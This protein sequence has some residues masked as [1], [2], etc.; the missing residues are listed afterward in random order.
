MPIYEYECKACSKRFDEIQKF[1]DPALTQCPSCGKPALE[2]LM[3]HSAFH[4]KGSGYYATDYKKTESK[5]APQA[6][7]EKKPAE[8]NPPKTSAEANTATK[9]EPKKSDDK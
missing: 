3:S 4:L 9:T 8:T 6:D 1:S 2:R 7:A 5:P